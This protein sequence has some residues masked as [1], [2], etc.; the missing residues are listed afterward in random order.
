MGENNNKQNKIMTDF[1]LL[2]SLKQKMNSLKA[3]NVNHFLK[4]KIRIQ[5]AP[6]V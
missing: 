6:L 2:K 4:I 3:K 1:K 5:P